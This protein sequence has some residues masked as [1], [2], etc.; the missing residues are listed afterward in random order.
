MALKQEGKT[1]D[2][3]VIGPDGTVYTNKSVSEVFAFLKLPR[4]GNTPEETK[5]LL[6]KR[7]EGWIGQ[8]GEAVIPYLKKHLQDALKD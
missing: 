2:G 8:Y 3:D 4:E 6:R 7:A 1:P 5:M